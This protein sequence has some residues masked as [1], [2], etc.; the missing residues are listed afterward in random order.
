[1]E[2]PSPYCRTLQPS[3][4]IRLP[5]FHGDQIAALFPSTERS[6]TL[7]KTVRRAHSRNRPHPPRRRNPIRN[8]LRTRTNHN[9][10]PITYTSGEQ[11]E[12]Y[13]FSI[14]VTFGIPLLALF[15]QAFMPLRFP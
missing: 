4:Q 14:P 6:R 8:R 15:V 7:P 3:R 5:P 10:V 12:V 13:R 9:T 11:V 2:V 1:M